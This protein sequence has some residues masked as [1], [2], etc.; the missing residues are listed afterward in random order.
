MQTKTIKKVITAKLEG[1]LASITDE[2][3][4]KDVRGSLL[5]S[6][7]CI[8]SMFQGLEVNDFDIYIQDMNVLV[9]LATYY[10]PTSV[11]DGRKKDDYIKERFP[12]YDPANP[13]WL[14]TEEPYAPKDLVRLE[15]LKPDQVKLDIESEGIRKDAPEDPLEY[16]VVFLSQNA[17]SL[18]GKIQIVLRFS[19]SPEE[20]HKN[21]DFIHATNYFTFKD[22]LVTNVPALESILTKE[23]KYQGSLYPLTS[24]IRMKKFINRG[25]KI[26]AGEMLKIMFQISETDLKDI[27]VLEE[28]LIGVDIAYFGLLIEALQ[29]VEQEKITSGYINTVIDRIFN[30]YDEDHEANLER[31]E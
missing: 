2:K 17:I 5:V 14:D 15:T 10:C 4:R 19:G 3:L 24:I 31:G 28:Q 26:N 9:R 6:G 1:W 22:G 30:Q 13:F 8:T 21:F 27:R 18:S 7:G 20:I 11:L 25:W 12:D 16:Q 29:T 23:L